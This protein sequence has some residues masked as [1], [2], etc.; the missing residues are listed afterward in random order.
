LNN[1]NEEVERSVSGIVPIPLI[2]NSDKDSFSLTV[3]RVNNIDKSSANF[4]FN[5]GE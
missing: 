1:N 3:S 5:N 2:V 4:G